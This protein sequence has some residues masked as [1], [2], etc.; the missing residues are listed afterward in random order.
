MKIMLVLLRTMGDVILGTTIC[1]ELK[2]EFPGCEIHFYVNKLYGPLLANN[3]YIDIVRESEWAFPDSLFMEMANENFDRIYTPYQVRG[4]CNMW[5]Q[6]EAHRRQHLL[7]FYWKRMGFHRHIEDRECYLF[8]SEEDFLV[9]EKKISFD[10]PRI[11]IHSTSGVATKDWGKFDDLVEEFRKAG[12]GCIQVGGGEDKLVRGAVD[13]RGKL[14]LMELAA[15]L[16]KCAL[17]IGLDSGVSYM[18][19]AMKTPSIVIQGSTDPVTSGPISKRVIH[20]FA[21]ETGYEDC[22]IVRCHVNCRHEV[23]CNT[24]ITPGMIMAEA[25]KILNA[26]SPMVPVRI[27]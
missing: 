13:L 12:Y 9:A 19:D 25:E 3:P 18:A 26:L 2:Q 10:V 17:F 15:F 8:P 7:D 14:S 20:L 5:H 24:R 23:N 27:D 1:R 4:E 11:A 21:K 6:Q 22:Q 16:S